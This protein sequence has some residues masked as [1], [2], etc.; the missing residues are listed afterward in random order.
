M[1]LP[2]VLF[3]FAASLVSAAAVLGPRSEAEPNGSPGLMCYADVYNTLGSNW[4]KTYASVEPQQIHLSLTDDAQFVRVQFA[5]LEQVDHS[6]L[7]YW[8]SKGRS[9]RVTTVEG[10]VTYKLLDL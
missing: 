10:K 3:T 4:N 1:L 7:K 5:T 8:P 9:K 2:S 6:I